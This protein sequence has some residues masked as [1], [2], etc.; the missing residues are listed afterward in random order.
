[1]AGGAAFPAEANP[2][3]GEKS[4]LEN[5]MLWGENYPLLGAV[6]QISQYVNIQTACVFVCVGHRK[7]Q[8]R[9][10]SVTIGRFLAISTNKYSLCQFDQNKLSECATLVVSV[11]GCGCVCVCFFTQWFAAECFPL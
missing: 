5:K 2:L 1:M 11:C 7:F 8:G 10:S 9:S 4:G 6:Q 3:R